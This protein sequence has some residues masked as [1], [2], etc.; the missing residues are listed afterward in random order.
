MGPI[1]AWVLSA[2]LTIGGVTADTAST[3]YALRQPGAQEANPLLGQSP[4]RIVALKAATAVPVLLVE[5]WAA[6]HHH[7]RLAVVIG[8]VVGGVT[9]GAAV[10]NVQLGKR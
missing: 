3:V 4:S 8:A 2:S 6:T 9:F 5:R 7:E 1:T 10:H